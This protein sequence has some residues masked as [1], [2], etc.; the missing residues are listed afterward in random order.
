MKNCNCCDSEISELNYE[1]FVVEYEE[2]TLPY[3][4]EQYEQDA[5]KDGPARR[6]AFNNMVDA[7]QKDNIISEKDAGEWCLPDYLD[8]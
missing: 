8:N 2:S 1:E 4:K 3:I 6:E 7:Y 5:V